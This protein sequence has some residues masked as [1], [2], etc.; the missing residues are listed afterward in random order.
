MPIYY[1]DIIDGQL[2][3]DEDGRT[4]PDASHVEKELKRRLSEIVLRAENPLQA[5]VN[6]RD[7]H[8]EVVATATISAAIH[9]PD[10]HH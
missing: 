10:T 7:E 1:F 5:L 4:L 6:V 8:R 2:Q 3:E 9:Y